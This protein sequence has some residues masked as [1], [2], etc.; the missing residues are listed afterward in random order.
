MGDLLERNNRVF[1][2]Q[3]SSVP[4]LM[5]K[6]KNEASAWI[7]VGAMGPAALTTRV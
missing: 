6:I 4:S 2:R 5:A 7:A 3:E 1:N